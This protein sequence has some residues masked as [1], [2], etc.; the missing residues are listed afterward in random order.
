MF[1]FYSQ[2][3]SQNV[4][5]LSEKN[6][7]GFFIFFNIFHVEKKIPKSRLVRPWLV[8]REIDIFSCVFVSSGTLDSAIGITC[9][10]TDLEL[11]LGRHDFGVGTSD[12][13][14]G[15]D[16]GP[17]M[18]LDDFTS[19]D[20]VS[21]NTA[22]IRTLGPGET[23][24]RPSQ[25]PPIKVKESVFLLDTEPRFVALNSFQRFVGT[26]ALVRLAWGLVAGVS[27]TKDQL[28]VPTSERI[29]VNRYGTKEHVAV[30]ALGLHGRAT[31]VRP[32]W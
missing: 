12:V 23:I 30:F 32:R 7:S 5:L 25:G 13:D 31:V 3:Y 18:S 10:K 15:E 17:V 2:F 11:P 21:S 22:V 8:A 6:F 27:V 16:A 20:F 28:V 26:E 9:E 1:W 19:D 4:D 29:F 14:T 24:F